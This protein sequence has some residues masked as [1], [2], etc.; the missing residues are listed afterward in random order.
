[1]F[2]PL[3]VINLLCKNI[4]IP[5][6]TPPKFPFG[7][8]PPTASS[9]STGPVSS[10]NWAATIRDLS[11]QFTLPLE[12]TPEH[13]NAAIDIFTVPPRMQTADDGLTDQQIILM[14][15]AISK[16][17]HKYEFTKQFHAQGRTLTFAHPSTVI[18]SN[19]PV[20]TLNIGQDNALHSLTFYID[21]RVQSAQFQ[22]KLPLPRDVQRRPPSGCPI[23][24]TIRLCRV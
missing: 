21:G 9:S 4:V 2:V 23:R 16:N 20:L 1:M 13:T 17:D 5:G 10:G 11:Q 7:Y 6:N 15:K 14:F 8:A 3:K 19:A 12:Q 24:T 18:N 22:Q